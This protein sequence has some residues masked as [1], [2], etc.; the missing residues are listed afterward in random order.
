MATNDQSPLDPYTQQLR[1]PEFGTASS[2]AV[3]ARGFIG[4]PLH[5]VA[6]ALWADSSPRNN[7]RRYQ[8]VTRRICDP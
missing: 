3:S 4:T 2:T 1:S 8:P 6:S 7:D 5:V